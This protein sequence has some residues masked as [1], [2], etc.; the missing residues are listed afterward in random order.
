MAKVKKILITGGSGFV[1]RNLL[2]SLKSIY[3]VVT[4]SSKTTGITTTDGV[5]DN[6]ANPTIK[7]LSAT[8]TNP[9]QYVE[10]TFYA[11]NEGEYT[12]YLNSVN[13]V[14]DKICTG[15]SGATDSLVQ[16][17]CEDI[18]L[19]V[20]VGDV[21]YEETSV[22]FNKSLTQG[23]GEL[24]KIR[25][26]YDTDGAYVDGDFSIQFP[27]IVFVYSTIDDATIIPPISDKLI[28][29]INGDLHT[30]GSIVSVLG[31][32][33]F[34]VI[35]NEDGN[36]KLLSMY[37]LRVGY[38][39]E[40]LDENGDVILKIMPDATGLQDA[41]VK[42]M[43][44]VSDFDYGFPWLGISTFVTENQHGNLLSDY[45]GSLVKVYVD[46]Y[47]DLAA[48]TGL[49]IVDARLITQSELEKL[50]CSVDNM[51]CSNAP[52]WVYSTSYW[53]GLSS[54]YNEVYGVLSSSELMKG[55]TSS[56]YLYGVRPVLIIPETEFEI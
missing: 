22:M 25:I 14:G 31:L 9:G 17:A 46:N 55:H 21:S 10:Y 29:V 13:F 16:S 51:S 8:F 53:V 7:N 5:I 6:G 27:N 41:E 32:E 42:G 11:R 2:E 19:I 45:E 52:S 4:P 3:D 24:I 26:E 34:Y 20:T 38:S 23:C 30:P 33:N 49:K 44:G 56:C 40:G 28:S 36:V 1:G 35:G 12:A 48:S 54:D 18:K 43:I 39:L 15:S 47:R 50:G 37:N